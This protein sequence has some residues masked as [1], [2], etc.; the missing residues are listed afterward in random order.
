VNVTQKE[1]DASDST[2][3]VVLTTYAGDDP[4]ELR[5]CLDSVC[6]QNRRPDELVVVRDRG[7]P[8][9]L[10]D[11]VADVSAPF[12]V[13]DVPVEERGRGHA[14]GVAVREATSDLVAVI[15]AD[16][17]A[18]PNRL[19]RQVAF[20]DANPSVDAVGGY[21]GEFETT[22]EEVRAVRT[23]PADP[24]AVRRMAH[25]RSPLNHPTVTFRRSAVLDV[26]NYRHME[27]GEDYELW[28]RMLAHGKTLA[29]VPEVLVKAR[30]DGLVT[31]RRGLDIARRE[32]RLQRAIVETGFYGWLVALANLAV[33]VP[34]RLLPERTLR[35][36]YRRVFRS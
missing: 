5:T 18:C 33:R 29:N 4:A 12:P 14:R 27:Y 6:E 2:V 17:V 35:R 25:Y 36:L 3:S 34:L 26:G 10:A 15:D 21:V 13:R 20:L 32:V 8:S 19:A 31:R 30:A 7:L 28:C 22:P 24:A 16:D 1:V 23:V 9:R 11:V